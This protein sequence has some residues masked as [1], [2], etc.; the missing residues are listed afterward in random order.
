MNPI[1]PTL[2]RLPTALAAVLAALACALF[3]TAAA[4]AAAAEGPQTTPRIEAELVAMSQWAAPGSTAVVAIRQTIQPGWHT[5]WRNPGDSGGATTLDWSLPAGVEADP[6]VWPLPQRQ[7]LQTLMNY[8]YSGEVVLPVPI[9]VPASA[10]PGTTL[11]LRVKALFLVCSDQMCVPDELTLSLDL[12]I[13]DGAAP[14]TRPWGPRIE[15]AIETAPRP[16]DI[17]ARVMLEGGTLRITAVGG[18]LAGLDLTRATFFPFEGDVIDHAAVQFGRRGPNGVTLDLA[19]DPDL[20][21][22]GLTGPVSGLLSTDAGAWEITATPGPA[23]PGSSGA[24][25]LAPTEDA[26]PAAPLTAM[27]V[28]QA[29]LF[30]FLGGLILN[31]MPCV[32]P[33]LAMKAASLTRSAHDPAEARRDGLAFLTGVLTTF[34]ILAGVLLAL[35]AGGQAIGW[36]FQLQSPAVVA[37]LALLMLAVALNLSGLFEIGGRLQAL[38]SSPL[39]RLP[40]GT[41]AFFTGVLAVV[42]AAPC[43]APFMA[44]ALGAALIMPAPLALI[45]FGLLGLGL[46]LPYVLISLSPGLLR[47]L[48]RPGPWMETLRRGLALPMYAAALW[49]VWVFARQTDGEAALWL[50]AACLLAVVAAAALGRFRSRAPWLGPAGA[51]ALILSL[52]LAGVSV[53]R[54]PAGDR[55]A[56]AL[57]ADAWSQARVE[58]A[59]A[60]GRPVLVN[61]TAD[62]CVSCKINER[63]ALSSPRVARALTQANAVYLEADWTRRDDVIARELQ[64]HG[65]SGVP[66]YL[67]YTPGRADPRILPQLLTEGMVVEALGDGQVD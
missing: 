51:A 40:G 14:L 12:P 62:W 5:Y 41:G 2:R 44:F 38:G 67:L 8:G 28:V 58:A 39:S 31:L 42:V 16:A 33:V 24:G 6:I 22:T 37:V 46:A 27:A 48:P 63:T 3:A 9:R 19:V 43:T 53:A 61:F 20:R 65:R 13:R 66:L 18:P 54:A 59:L 10:R 11:P 60:Q 56:H 23:L 64:R 17:E 26:E 50:V 4:A 25:D 49:L 34:L 45:V 1:S 7:R 15:T 21:K 30:A 47:R 35:R 32:F 55:E 57:P 52:A 36:G 29:G